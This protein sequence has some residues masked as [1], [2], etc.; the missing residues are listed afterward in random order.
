MLRNICS[1]SRGPD[2]II[3]MFDT[4]ALHHL[5]MATTSTLWEEGG[6]VKYRHTHTHTCM[7]L[8]SE[9]CTIQLLCNL[10]SEVCMCI[11]VSSV[12]GSI[13]PDAAVYICSHPDLVNTHVLHM[14][15]YF[16]TGNVKLPP[17]Y[18]MNIGWYLVVGKRFC[19]SLL[20]TNYVTILLSPPC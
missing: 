9:V 5:V 11:C 8:S 16:S 10:G 15:Y 2:Q 3:R 17:T 14:E 6:S 20:H 12:L 19:R 4:P 13:H 1:T 18:C 7:C